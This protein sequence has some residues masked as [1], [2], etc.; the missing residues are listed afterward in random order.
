MAWDVPSLLYEV[1]HKKYPVGHQSRSPQ[2][3]FVFL[4]HRGSRQNPRAGSN[5]PH[6]RSEWLGTFLRGF[7]KQSIRSIPSV[8]NQEAPKG[9]L[10]FYLIGEA[11]RTREAG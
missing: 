4:S 8:I 11:D 10:F 6:E 2:R 7:T 5:V 3:G 1:K 9:G